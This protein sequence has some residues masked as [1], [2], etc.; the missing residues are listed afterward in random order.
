MLLTETEGFDNW[1]RFFMRSGYTRCLS[2]DSRSPSANS[3]GCCDPKAL[4]VASACCAGADKAFQ[5]A[6][7]LG[8]LGGREAREDGATVDVCWPRRGSASAVAGATARASLV[9]VAPD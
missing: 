6:E 8:G 9:R 5:E 2:A 1:V 7:W 3:E 4:P